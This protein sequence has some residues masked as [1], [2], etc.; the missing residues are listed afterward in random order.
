MA[1]KRGIYLIWKLQWRLYVWKRQEKIKDFSRLIF[2]S[3]MMYRLKGHHYIAAFTEW[4]W[5]SGL[6]SGAETSHRAR[7]WRRLPGRS[8]H[9]SPGLVGCR[10][11]ELLRGWDR[12]DESRRRMGSLR[13][14]RPAR[15]PDT[16]L[17]LVTEMITIGRYRSE[18]WFPQTSGKAVV[19]TPGQEEKYRMRAI[20][21]CGIKPAPDKS[22]WTVTDSAARQAWSLI[23]NPKSISDIT[24]DSGFVSR[25][26][27]WISPENR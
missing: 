13:M 24:L 18:K 1:D 19:S 5:E 8:N 2:T 16:I 26:T 14:L 9:R 4:R 6:G 17:P 3:G 20:T 21:R 7:I 25:F 10:I 11:N 12:W 22:E 27:I 15:H 23:C